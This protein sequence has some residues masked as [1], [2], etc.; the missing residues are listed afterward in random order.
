MTSIFTGNSK[1]FDVIL[2]LSK[3]DKSIFKD[4]LM[5]DHIAC[6]RDER[7]IGDPPFK[8]VHRWIYHHVNLAYGRG[9]YTP[10]VLPARVTN[11]TFPSSNL[12]ATLSPLTSLHPLP[13]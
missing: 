1:K 3:D 9:K 7:G 4:S 10:R 12:T 8:I 11:L 2:S 5:Y 6:Y 13:L